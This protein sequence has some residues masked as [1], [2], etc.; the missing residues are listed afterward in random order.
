L[1]KK[2]N[3]T[4][5]RKSKIKK[6][7]IG[8]LGRA[9]RGLGGFGGNALGSMVGQGQ[10]GSQAGTS[11]GAA[12][13]KWLGAGDYE[14]SRNSVVAK[15]SNSIPNMHK[16]DQTVTIRHR[17]YIG[18]LSGSSAFTVQ[19]QLPV[20]PGAASTF[21]WLSEIAQRFQEY[22]IK[23]MVYHY[24]PTSGYA[25][26]GTNSALGSVM[27][28]TTYCSTEGAPTTKTEMLN[29]YW[30][31]EVVPSETM[32]HPIECDPKE[33]PFSIHYVR[34]HGATVGEPLLYDLGKTFIATSGMQG[35]NVVGDI[36]VTYEVELKKPV[37]RSDIATLDNF[38]GISFATPSKT[39]YYTTTPEITPIG[40]LPLT[41][42]G[43]TITFPIGLN[44]NFIVSFSF[45]SDTGLTSFVGG[46]IKF[47]GAA[48]AT[49]GSFYAYDGVNQATSTGGS[50]AAANTFT[51]NAQTYTL[52]FYKP[53][54]S[55]VATVLLPAMTY[56]LGSTTRALTFVNQ[57]AI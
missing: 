33:N 8:L 4:V 40:T 56:D 13:S 5:K 12:V 41:F 18:Q 51:S 20:Q 1:N 2:T 26:S 10:A 27:M 54:A 31:N 47:V 28:H 49:N 29:E 50:A 9:L 55:T 36:W 22:S 35:T 37:I 38:I 42:S 3:K 21:P 17:E 53:E 39:V 43:R 23:G 34:S 32:C 44:G 45:I 19:Y 16:N 48:T 52:G 7:E 57:V 30:A 14:V 24:I 25:I 11:L 6:N 46:D 15:A